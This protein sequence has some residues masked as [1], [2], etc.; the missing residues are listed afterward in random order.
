[1]RTLAV[2]PLLVVLAAC[3]AGPQQRTESWAPA[4]LA[5]LCDQREVR[6]LS[7][8]SPVWVAPVTRPVYQF[9]A[10]FEKTSGQGISTQAL[11]EIDMTENYARR[12]FS[13]SRL[14][15]DGCPRLRLTAAKP[16]KDTAWLEISDRVANPFVSSKHYGVFAR[17]S[18]GGLPG[19]T[20][21]WLELG[22]DAEGRYR[23]MG[24]VDLEVEDQ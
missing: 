18:L 9:S 20:W 8:E 2:G 17:L 12:D 4:V 21:Y 15:G 3:S 11:S 7:R 14:S 19:A 5:S 16:R 23:V 13:S 10:L 1:M 22:T 24:A 6:E